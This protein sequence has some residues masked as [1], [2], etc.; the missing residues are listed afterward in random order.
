MNK[1]TRKKCYVTTCLIGN[2][3]LNSHVEF[4]NNFYIIAIS[5]TNPKIQEQYGKIRRIE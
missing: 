1:N 4:H 2:E 3:I 5:V